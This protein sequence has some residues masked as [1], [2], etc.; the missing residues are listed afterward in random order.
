M[1]K[2]FVVQPK[3]FFGVVTGNILLGVG[4][5]IFKYSH[6]GNDPFTAMVMALHAFVPFSFAVFLIMLNSLIFIFEAV[7]GKKFIGIGTIINWFMVGYV[8]Q[9]SVGFLEGNFPV[10]EN[11]FVQLLAVVIGVILASLGLSLYQTSD[12]GVSPYDSLPLIVNQYLSVPYFWSRIFFDAVCAL[13][14]YLSG[15]L[16][17]IGTLV[18]A[19]GLGPIISF[20]NKTVSEKILLPKENLVVNPVTSLE[21]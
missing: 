11:F 4:V 6:M 3:R 9:Y 19:F 10:L 15:G 13:I 21:E 14:A 12:A 20:F 8:V 18:C 16:I 2:R 5:G 1:L 7:F 17:G